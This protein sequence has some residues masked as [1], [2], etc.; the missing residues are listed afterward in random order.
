MY[1]LIAPKFSYEILRRSL[2]EL[3]HTTRQAGRAVKRSIYFDVY[4]QAN[5]ATSKYLLTKTLF[6][7]DRHLMFE[8]QMYYAFR[9]VK[10]EICR[11][12]KT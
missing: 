10:L 1:P 3:P 8:L 11:L 2:S 6:C 7:L 12:N 5:C 4:G 9:N